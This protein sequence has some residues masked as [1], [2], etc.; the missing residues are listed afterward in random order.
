MKRIVKV[1]AVVAIMVMA[2]ACG[3]A[4]SPEKV[5]EKIKVRFG[6]AVAANVDEGVMIDYRTPKGKKGILQRNLA[7]VIQARVQ[8][9]A[10]MVVEEI[11]FAGY[12]KKLPYGIV[13]TGGGA[14]LADIAEAFTEQTKIDTRI[15]EGTTITM[16][17]AL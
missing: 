17:V 3:S 4:S 8:D 10:D 2:A 12:E 5:V 14:N 16:K 7:T 11:K 9:M 13:L 6:S 1:L 15:G